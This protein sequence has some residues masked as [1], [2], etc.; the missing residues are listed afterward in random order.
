MKQRSRGYVSQ[1]VL[2][3]KYAGILTI[4]LWRIPGHISEIHYP[5]FQIRVIDTRFFALITAADAKISA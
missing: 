3:F 1:R 4:L 2:F 5:R